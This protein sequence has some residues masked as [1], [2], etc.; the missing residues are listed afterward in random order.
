[1]KTP[2]FFILGAPKCGTTSMVSWVSEHPCAYL[3][4]WKEP[5]Y[6]DQDLK[7]RFRITEPQ[8]LALFE[9][10]TEQHIAMGEAT[11]WSPFPRQAVSDIEREIPGARDIVMIRNPVVKMAYALQ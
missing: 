6:F 5:R 4:P 9:G 3:S 1:M 11:V 8:Y 2:N 10:A 7:T